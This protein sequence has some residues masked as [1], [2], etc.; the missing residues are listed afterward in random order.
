MGTPEDVAA[1]KYFTPPDADPDG[2]GCAEAKTDTTT[3]DRVCPDCNGEGLSTYDCVCHGG[4]MATKECSPCHTCGGTG[5]VSVLLDSHERSE[6]IRN[7]ELVSG[8]MRRK[9]D[10]DDLSIIGRQVNVML[11]A[12]IKAQH[13]KTTVIAYANGRKDALIEVG[14]WLEGHYLDESLEL[15]KFLK[16][17]VMLD[18]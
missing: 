7:V 16:R 18:E 9:L 5:V 1:E 13:T 14:K 8:R 6:V 12:V 15:V 3:W 4:G 11:T 17:G 2:L 10:F